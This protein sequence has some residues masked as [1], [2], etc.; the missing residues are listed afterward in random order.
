MLGAHRCLP[1]VG[2][3]HG[4][5][6]RWRA[7]RQRAFSRNISR[8]RN[9]IQKQP[10]K[11]GAH[12]EQGVRQP[13]PLT[14]WSLHGNGSSPP[15]GTCN[16]LLLGSYCADPAAWLG[17]VGT[18]LAVAYALFQDTFLEWWRRPTLSLQLV[19]EDSS[20]VDYFKRDRF[21]LRLRVENA[22][23]SS[24]RQLRL[25]VEGMETCA[26]GGECWQ[27]APVFLAGL[28]TWTHLDTHQLD[29]LGSGAW[30]PVDCLHL[31]ETS[32]AGFECLLAYKTRAQDHQYYVVSRHHR[33]TLRLE[34]DNAGASLYQLAFMAPGALSKDEAFESL[35]PRLRPL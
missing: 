28:L 11:G 32:T 29:Y 3:R 14:T 2:A 24:A 4:W 18:V 21:V 10:E 7:R 9:M 22:G 30:R 34:A 35:R 15:M 23:R 26:A 6:L 16:G 20:Y 33:L 25:A 8:T 27:P 5:A 17:A 1:E 13:Q 12:G 31:D 19:P